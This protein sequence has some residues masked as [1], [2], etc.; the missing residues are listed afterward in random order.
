[1]TERTLLFDSE[2]NIDIL[3]RIA[4][5]IEKKVWLG[6]PKIFIGN[7]LD[8][9]RKISKD[10]FL[11][12]LSEQIA[13][14]MTKEVL[15]E[16]KKNL[17]M[18]LEAFD[19]DDFL[20]S[21]AAS[22]ARSDIEAD[23]GAD[24]WSPLGDQENAKSF[25]NDLSKAKE[26]DVD[27]HASDWKQAYETFNEQ[28]LNH[29]SQD[30]ELNEFSAQSPH[31]FL[32]AMAVAMY[33]YMMDH[34]SRSPFISS[35]QQWIIDLDDQFDPT[36]EEGDID[37][38]HIE[39]RIY[40]ML[41]SFEK[42]YNKS[43]MKK[44]DSRSRVN[45]LKEERAQLLSMLREVWE[46][47]HSP[48][49]YDNVRE[50]LHDLPHEE[51]VEIMGEWDAYEA[52]GESSSLMSADFDAVDKTKYAH[53]PNDVL[54]DAIYKKAEKLSN[55]DNGGFHFWV[56]PYGCHKVSADAN[57]E[58]PIDEAGVKGKTAPHSDMIRGEHDPDQTYDWNVLFLGSLNNVIDDQN[59]IYN[60]SYKEAL[61]DARSMM[62]TIDGAVDVDLEEAHRDI[63]YEYNINLDERGSFYA[64]VRDE[65][66]KTVFTI[67]AGDE[68]ED[69]ESSIFDDGYMKHKNDLR[70]LEEYLKQLGIM[71]PG[72]KL[73]S[74]YAEGVV[75][76]DIDDMDPD[77]GELSDEIG[78]DHG[79]D[80]SPLEDVSYGYYI[81]PPIAT[82]NR[83]YVV[84]ADGDPVS[85]HDTEE[86]AK[87]A[88]SQLERNAIG[89]MGI[90]FKESAEARMDR[91]LSEAEA[92]MKEYR[93]LV[94]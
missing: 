91:L 80:L 85:D 94:R 21:D 10:E 33:K 48:E 66:G 32:D 83:W 28:L 43:V 6:F 73:V 57:Q 86:E 40:R 1:M 44:A 29:L 41:G 60:K 22:A 63:K 51:L 59:T 79:G 82:D 12:M 18:K 36:N 47:G 58:N 20:W 67:K 55:T 4:S 49:A 35:I 38:N 75:N 15:K 74:A 31:D 68:L 23:Q 78:Y 39:G 24:S 26:K 56:C 3:S 8:M 61:N 87:L 72:S 25:V 53:L 70:G 42:V 81:E 54:A 27:S 65:D 16:T 34:N 52:A 5:K 45:Q 92:L 71:E 84:N 2:T 19:T 89:G 13:S 62:H 93:A 88:M 76:E 30:A 69:G 11:D 77:G 90:D 50:N 14:H 17:E 64:D 37:L 7:D 9:K 46:W